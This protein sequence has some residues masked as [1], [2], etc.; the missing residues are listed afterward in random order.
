MVTDHQ[1]SV[2]K[3][4]LSKGKPLHV[5]ACK[6]GISEKTAKKHR[7]SGQG[8]KSLFYEFLKEVYERLSLS[9]IE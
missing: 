9:I 5:S 2:L 8:H 4:M 6:A 1:V 7:S 3:Q